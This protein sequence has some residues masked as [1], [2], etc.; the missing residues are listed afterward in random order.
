MTFVIHKLLKEMMDVLSEY[1]ID[2]NIEY[3]DCLKGLK[4]LRKIW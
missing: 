3:E 1:G 4:S 2:S